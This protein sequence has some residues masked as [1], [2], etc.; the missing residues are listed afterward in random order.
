VFKL[1]DEATIKRLGDRTPRQ[2]IGASGIG[3]EC[4][5]YQ[6]LC[7]RGFPN[8]DLTGRQLRIFQQGH[9]LEM[10]VVFDMKAAGLDVDEVDPSTG[11]QWEFTALGQ[12]VVAHLDGIARI[13]GVAHLLEVK[14]MNRSRWMTFKKKGVKVSDPKYYDQCQLAML[15]A[16][17]AHTMFVAVNKDN[18]EYHVEILEIDDNRIVAL[19]LRVDGSVGMKAK[20]ISKY[21]NA[22]VCS[23]CFKSDACWRG[24][25]QDEPTNCA[26]CAHATPV[27]AG[28]DKKAWHCNKHDSKADSICP[29]FKWFQPT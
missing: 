23:M 3:S 4:H 14:T 12:H 18:S 15:L 22:F 25:R 1:I 10:E 13:D 7:L 8:N 21:P 17:L 16:N 29:E 19:S 9:L 26:Q 28:P 24:R 27:I 20:R 11:E 5:A 2:Y 6:A